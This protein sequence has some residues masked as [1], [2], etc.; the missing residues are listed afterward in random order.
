MAGCDSSRLRAMAV[1]NVCCANDAQSDAD[2]CTRAAAAIETAYWTQPYFDNAIR[3]RAT[4]GVQPDCSLCAVEVQ[5]V[6]SRCAVKM[7]SDC[8]RFAVYLRSLCRP[9]S[10]FHSGSL[11][12][13]SRT[14]FCVAGVCCISGQCYCPSSMPWHG[15]ATRD[16]G[17]PRPVCVV[18]FA[19]GLPDTALAAMAPPVGV[20]PSLSRSPRLTGCARETRY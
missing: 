3:N 11:S 9:H 19:A 10:L 8:S 13:E 14:S 16:R 17:T 12:D 7:Q 1:R 18:V 4:G 2:C 20:Q 5:S 6:C 15:S